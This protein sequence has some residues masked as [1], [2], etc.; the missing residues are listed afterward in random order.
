M[1]TWRCCARVCARPATRVASPVDKAGDSR[2]VSEQGLRHLRNLR[3]VRSLRPGLQHGE[4]VVPRR[5]VHGIVPQL[6]PGTHRSNPKGLT[7]HINVLAKGDV[8]YGQEP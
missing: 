5:I 1:V 7:A 6:F 8:T 3:D 2:I 4:R